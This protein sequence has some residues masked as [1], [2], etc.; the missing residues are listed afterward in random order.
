VSSPLATSNSATGAGLLRLPYIA[1]FTSISSSASRGSSGRH[2][3]RLPV[4]EP[5][6][7]VRL[8]Q[9]ADHLTIL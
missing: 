4:A 1:L 3:G 2:H 9:L 8:V 6:L 7:P 5:R